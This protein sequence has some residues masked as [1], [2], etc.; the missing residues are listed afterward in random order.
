MKFEHTVPDNWA[1]HRVSSPI[2]TNTL[3]QP[4]QRLRLNVLLVEL[5]KDAAHRV[6]LGGIS[7]LLRI[8]QLAQQTVNARRPIPTAAFLLRR[9]LVLVG[10]VFH[11][12]VRNFQLETILSAAPVGQ[13]LQQYYEI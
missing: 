6:A 3:P 1:Q 4:S 9:N 2:E 12:A 11:D 13:R 5:E 7:P 8:R 10:N